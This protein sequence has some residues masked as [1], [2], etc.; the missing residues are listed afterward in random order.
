MWRVKGLKRRLKKELIVKTVYGE[1]EQSKQNKRFNFIHFKL[2][3]KLIV[4]LMLWFEKKV[5]KKHYREPKLLQHEYVKL[6]EDV[7]N[8]ANAQWQHKY[9]QSLNHKKQ[10]SLDECR[11]KV[12]NNEGKAS[13]FLNLIKKSGSLLFM[14]DDAYMEW[15]PFFMY[16]CYSQMGAKLESKAFNKKAYHLLHTVPKTLD[17]D[18]EM[19]YLSL[20]QIKNFEAMPVG[21][22]TRID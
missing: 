19:V 22:Q 9:L 8:E 10:L 1:E 2:K 17:P 11:E 5:L 7:F 14:N 20:R 6:W 18:Y 3:Y 21:K 15:L 16:E 12:K 13:R 4:P